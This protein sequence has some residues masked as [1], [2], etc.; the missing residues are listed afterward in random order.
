MIADERVIHERLRARNGWS[1]DEIRA[2]LASQLPLAEKARRAT[3]VIENSGDLE[4]ARRRVRE[5]MERWTGAS[6]TAH[7]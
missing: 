4:A 7:R 1:D 5:L 2:R 3:H 6:G